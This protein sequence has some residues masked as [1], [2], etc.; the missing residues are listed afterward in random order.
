VDQVFS[1]FLAVS[2]PEGQSVSC[3][4]PRVSNAVPPKVPIQERLDPK[5]SENAAVQKHF[6]WNHWHWLPRHEFSWWCPLPLPQVGGDP[7]ISLFGV[8]DGHGARGDAASGLVKHA[9]E[10]M[11]NVAAVRKAANSFDGD[12]KVGIPSFDVEFPR[13]K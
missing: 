9:A 13:K 11:L 2:R 10:S 12:I 6:P 4:G 1:R 7:G 3:L 5:V 8:F